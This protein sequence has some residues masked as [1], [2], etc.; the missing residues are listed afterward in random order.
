MFAPEDREAPAASPRTT[1]GDFEGGATL[2]SY[3]G[4]SCLNLNVNAN[5]TVFIC[6]AVIK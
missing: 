2:R 4:G 1:G 6:T 5:V 3:A